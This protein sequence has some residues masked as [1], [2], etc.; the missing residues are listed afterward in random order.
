VQ[1]DA[2]EDEDDEEQHPLGL[3]EDGVHPEEL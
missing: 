2:Y 1:Q 3:G